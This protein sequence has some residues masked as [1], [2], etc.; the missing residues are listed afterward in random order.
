MISTPFALPL[1]FIG[2]PLEKGRLPTFIY[3]SI[4]AHESLHLEPYCQPAQMLSHEGI[5]VFSMTLP[6]HGPGF[7][8]ITAISQWGEAMRKGI[9]LIAPFLEKAEKTIHWLSEQNIVS[10][11]AIGGLSRGA[12][13]ATH[14]AARIK[15]IK[16]LVGFAPLVKLS[17]A[18]GFEKVEKSTLYDLENLT[19]KLTH[20]DHVRFY[21]GNRDT[22]VDTDAVYHFI[23]ALAESA[24]EKR[25]RS[26][27]SEL[28]ISHAIG[29]EGHGTSTAIFRQGADF[30]KHCLQEEI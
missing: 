4:S 9:D 24:Y 15:A 23:R 25:V 21:I 5:R 19:G 29:R 6:A 12:F 14:L 11:L 22:L 16:T 27:Q 1:D 30:I 2:P 13:F 28:T 26:C 8:K 18:R 17:T 7:D 10:S 3:F 20:L